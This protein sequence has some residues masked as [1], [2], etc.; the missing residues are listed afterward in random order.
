MLDDAKIIALYERRDETAIT[1][2][3]AKYGRYCRSIA[4]NIISDASTTE[5][6]TNDTYLVAWN[7]IPPTKPNCLKAFLAKITRNLSLKR[8]RHDSA[9]KRGGNTIQ[10]PLE[11]LAECADL[12]GGVIEHLEAAELTALIDDFLSQQTDEIRF[13]FVRRY[14]Y[15]DSIADIAHATGATEGKVKMTLKRTRDKLAAHLEKEGYHA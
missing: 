2:T 4:H 13:M 10:I 6:I 5:E 15:F 7:A 9:A 8:F 1:Q 11:E 12:S 3:D 14:W